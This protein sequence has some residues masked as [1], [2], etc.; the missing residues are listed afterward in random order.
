MPG[1]IRNRSLEMIEKSERRRRRTV[2]LVLAALAL[3]LLL[4]GGGVWIFL[5]S[6]LGARPAAKSYGTALYDS[7]AQSYQMCIRD[8]PWAND[9][10]PYR[11]PEKFMQ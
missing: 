10:R 5:R 8:S 11:A 9:V 6:D 7:T 3:L 1:S 4:V 2:A